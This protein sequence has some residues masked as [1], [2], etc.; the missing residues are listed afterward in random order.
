MSEEMGSLGGKGREVDEVVGRWEEEAGWNGK[1]GKSNGRLVEARDR[2]G[3]MGNT[4]M[5]VDIRS[6][7]VN[8]IGRVLSGRGWDRKGG[9]GSGWQ[10]EGIGWVGWEGE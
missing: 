4:R 6:K 10:V 3:G 7:D 5:G 2:L 8:R 1:G 9:E